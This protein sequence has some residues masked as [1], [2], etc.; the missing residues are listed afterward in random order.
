MMSLVV[1]LAFV[2]FKLVECIFYA[3]VYF[4]T[5]I[6]SRRTLPSLKG[7]IRGWRW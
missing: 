1:F 4:C 2:A 5:P 3:L 6:T 7:G